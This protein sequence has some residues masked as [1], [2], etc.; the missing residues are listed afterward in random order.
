MMRIRRIIFII[1]IM[2]PIILSF[3]Q[4]DG[5]SDQVTATT[6][7]NGSFSFSY[8]P[9]LVGDWIV[10]PYWESEK[11][12]YTSVTGISF[13]ILV[14]SINQ[15]DL[16]AETIILLIIATIIIAVVIAAIT[17]FLKKRKRQSSN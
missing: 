3:L 14:D 6:A 16:S 4:P 5:T 7:K 2:S 13:N 10:S 9:E 1:G 8:K 12:Y 17:I 11:S 15:V